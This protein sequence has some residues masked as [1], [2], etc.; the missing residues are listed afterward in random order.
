MTARE[1]AQPAHQS[2]QLRLEDGGHGKF[3]ALILPP[4]KLFMDK[5]QMIKFQ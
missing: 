1:G 3:A 2:T 4:H 5:S